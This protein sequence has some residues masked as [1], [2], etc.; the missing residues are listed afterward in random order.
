[1]VDE[2]TY[3]GEVEV[4]MAKPRIFSGWTHEKGGNHEA[5][6][7]RF[8]LRASIQPRGMQEMKKR[9]NDRIKS[10]VYSRPCV[11]RV[12]SRTAS[13]GMKIRGRGSAAI[14]VAAPRMSSLGSR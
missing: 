6:A 2:S 3:E 7:T 10:R 5:G 8:T 4:K 13:V 11:A 9:E 1:M 12:G 14:L